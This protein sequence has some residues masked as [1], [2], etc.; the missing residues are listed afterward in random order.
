MADITGTPGNDTLN[1]TSGDDSIIGLEGNDTIN[2]GDGNDELYGETGNDTLNGG[3][4]SDILSGWLGDD[5]LT[6]GAGADDFRPGL[7]ANVIMDYQDGVDLINVF[8]MGFTGFANLMSFA[9]QV[10]NDVVIT[11]TIDEFVLSSL[12]IRNVTLAQ[13]NESDFHFFPPPGSIVSG[14]EGDDLLYGLGGDFFINYGFGGNDTIVVGPSG[15]DRRIYAGEGDDTVIITDPLSSFQI[16]G[17]AGI[18]T[19]VVRLRA[20]Q[21]VDN[22][23][24]TYT[25]TL[26]NVGQQDL[27]GFE[28]LR[29]ESTAGT[30]LTVYVDL[31]NFDMQLTHLIGGA[32]SDTVI[33]RSYNGLFP[34]LTFTNWSE[35]DTFEY[36]MSSVDTDLALSGIHPGLFHIVG[37]NLSNSI[38]G[39]DSRDWLEGASGDDTL[40][41]NGGDDRLDGGFGADV[42]RGGEGNDR[43]GSGDG[44]VPSD[45]S[46][47]D[48][49]EGGNGDDW[50]AFGYGD[51]ATGGAGFDVAELS[52]LG[53]GSGV[54]INLADLLAGV[55]GANGG[56]T[57]TGV[58]GVATI[59]G[60]AFDDSFNLAGAAV[61]VANG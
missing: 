52:Y 60:S 42:L 50:L 11:P 55:S 8:D 14:S 29:L 23:S 61:Y 59:Y 27:R 49:L 32:G 46:S 16:I 34:T 5:I 51:S 7:G 56:G 28:N 1:G 54:S 2:G 38:T 45:Q 22:L 20:A 39:T 58:E 44:G 36:Q 33:S 53:L 37:S 3:N 9:R 21:Q 26:N 18:D 12:T 6:G 43:L 41:G 48:L 4:G 30:R 15:I 40:I 25:V 47:I 10:G 35:D 24:Q 57:V 13:L 17:D 19:L 31:L